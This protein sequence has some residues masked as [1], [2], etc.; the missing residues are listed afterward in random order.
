VPIYNAKV[1]TAVASAA[2]VNRQI[3]LLQADLE[4][5]K[6]II[7]TEAEKVASKRGS[8]EQVEFSSPEGVCSVCFVQDAVTPVDGANL[9]ELQTVLPKVTWSDLFEEKVVLSI[10]F[11]EKFEALTGKLRIAVRRYVQWDQRAPRV[12]LP[13]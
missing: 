12:T 9:R 11:S 2:V 5:F 3:K 1:A 13:K 8:E 4:G 7:R 6:D 10:G